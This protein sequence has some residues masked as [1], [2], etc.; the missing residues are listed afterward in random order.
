MQW[1]KNSRAN[2]SYVYWVVL[3]LNG[4]WTVDAR[5]LRIITDYFSGPG[6]AIGR[7]YV[8]ISLQ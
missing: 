2:C 8:F 4:G 7:T 5:I 6:R 1:T 3:I